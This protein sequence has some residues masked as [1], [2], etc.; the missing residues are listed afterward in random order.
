M[1]STRFTPPPTITTPETDRAALVALY[2]STNGPNWDDSDNW[3]SDAPLGE[4][5]GVITDD[6]DRVIQLFLH[7][8]ELSGE[9]PPE[10][11]N[12]SNLQYLYLD[13]NHQ[14]SGYVPTG[15]LGQ[16]ESTNLG[17]LPPC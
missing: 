17:G 2:N 14:L 11:G 15:M 16:L 12:L 13:R 4:W 5:Y 10:L 3:L 6:N 1:S 9:I 8:N 7:K